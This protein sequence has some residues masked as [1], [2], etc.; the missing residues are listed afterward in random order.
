MGRVSGRDVRLSAGKGT[1]VRRETCGGVHFV[2]TVPE[3]VDR[4]VSF[5]YNYRMRCSCGGVEDLSAADYEAEINELTYRARAVEEVS[6]SVGAL[7]RCVI[8]TIPRW[9][10]NSSVGWPGTTRVRRRTG[11]R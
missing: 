1:S 8:S 4:P 3:L 7:P 11:P 5:A 6:T 9:R 10:T 2:T